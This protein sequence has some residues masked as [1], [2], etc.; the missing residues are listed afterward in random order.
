METRMMYL[1]PMQVVAFPT[2]F[3]NH[4]VN[5]FALAAVA[6]LLSL[7]AWSAL[8]DVSLSKG[9]AMTASLGMT[10]AGVCLLLAALVLVI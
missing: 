4:L 3:G 1:P 6:V 7:T 10:L 5:G 8:G 9:E 2:V